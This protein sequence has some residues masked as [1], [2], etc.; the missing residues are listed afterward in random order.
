MYQ[1][2]PNSVLMGEAN[3]LGVCLMALASH[4]TLPTPTTK[5]TLHGLQRA[6]HHE[7]ADEVTT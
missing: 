2:H 1:L 7:P 5:P 6:T 3:Q 4:L